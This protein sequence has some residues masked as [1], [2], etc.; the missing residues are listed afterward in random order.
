MTELKG[1]IWGTSEVVFNSNGIEIHRIKVKP[2]GFCSLHKHEHKSNLFFV[3]HGVLKISVCKNDYDLIDD[4][5]LNPGDKT[6]VSPGEF[7]K[8]ESIEGE[9][10]AYEIYFTTLDP[11]DI[12][13]KDVGG[14]K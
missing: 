3:E 11:E 8:F 14:I 9:V 5:Y 2:G 13:R 10:I 4:T 6:T 7:H 1:K 12:V